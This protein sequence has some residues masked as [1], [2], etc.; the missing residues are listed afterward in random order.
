MGVKR[1]WGNVGVP[2]WKKENGGRESWEV[3][4]MSE[5]RE[6]EH[7]LDGHGYF[8]GGWVEEGAAAPTVR[9][10]RKGVGER[11]VMRTIDRA[12]ESGKRW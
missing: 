11:K 5:Q 9:L 2:I 7:T 8:G 10:K 4:E 3:C 6:A 1:N 12:E